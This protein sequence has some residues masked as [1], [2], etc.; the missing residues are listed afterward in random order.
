LIQPVI[1]NDVCGHYLVL[2]GVKCF[3]FVYILSQIVPNK[4][5][6]HVCIYWYTLLYVIPNTRQKRE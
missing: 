3:I 5:Q 1:P 4:S 2:H 6:T